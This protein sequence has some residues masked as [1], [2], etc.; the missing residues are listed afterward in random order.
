MRYDPD[1]DEYYVD[2]PR[3]RHGRLL[4]LKEDQ[5]CTCCEKGLQCPRSMFV[6]AIWST[7]ITTPVPEE[8]EQ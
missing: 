4:S 3:G 6:G 1:T 5:E 8:V 7:L 2:I